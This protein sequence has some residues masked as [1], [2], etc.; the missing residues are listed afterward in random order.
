MSLGPKKNRDALASLGEVN[1]ALQLGKLFYEKCELSE[2][3]DAF[4]HALK[5][6][7]SAKQYRSAMEATVGL[8]RLSRE[9]LD[10]PAVQSLDSKLDTLM[11]SH[12]ES[13][14]PMAWYCKGAVARQADQYGLALRYFRRYLRAARADSTGT[15]YGVPLS[16]DHA[17]A[18]AWSAIA[19]AELERGRLTR[20]QFIAQ[21]VLKRY[22]SKAF[23]GVNGVIYMIL[24]RACE[25]AK[26][27]T[28]AQEWYEK[29]NAAF[30]IERNWYY[31]LHV[32]RCFARVAR[33]SQK[34]AQAYWYLDLLDKA[35][36]APEFKSFRADV[37]AERERLE[38]DAV[39]LLI[40]R[41]KSVVKVRGARSVSLGKQHILLNILEAL[42]AGK[43]KGLTKSELIEKVWHERYVPSDHDNRLYYN[44]NR[45]RKLIEPEVHKPKFLLSWREGYRLAPG[46]R[47]QIVEGE[48]T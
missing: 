46:L 16:R 22:E 21:A 42:A 29:A 10:H 32:L 3:K 35:T 34:Y 11:H 36:V 18:Q 7:K 13:V 47:V 6:A 24:G 48:E 44:I 2:S 19:V 33:R 15:A 12:S 45:L 31:H 8:I 1:R 4:V 26:D 28:A 23:S 38:Q 9:A 17:V 30:L 39:D 20:G 14:P 37:I 40:D 25:T 41:R 5:L 43:S 27:W